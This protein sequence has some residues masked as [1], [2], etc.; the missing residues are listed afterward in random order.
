[1]THQDGSAH[2]YDVPDDDEPTVA[3]FRPRK[4]QSWMR[5]VSKAQ[6]PMK[7]GKYRVAL[8]AGG[9]RDVANQMREKLAKCR[10]YIK[11]HWE[12]DKEHSWNGEAH[13]DVD[14]AIFLKDFASHSQQ[15][16]F[17]LEMRDKGLRWIRTQRKMAAFTGALGQQGIRT[18]DAHGKRLEPL[19]TSV[20]FWG[21]D[22]LPKPKEKFP[23]PPKFALDKPA[24][25]DAAS[26]LGYRVAP[27]AVVDPTKLDLVNPLP[28]VNFV[29]QQAISPV[30]LPAPRKK[31][32]SPQLAVLASLLHQMCADEEVQVLCSPKELTFTAA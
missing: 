6:I 10:V 5:N 7:N 25:E 9:P 4:L 27:L 15:D 30:S 14:F 32:P 12:S 18:V 16:K 3:E 29:V 20:M 31:M 11:Y 21:E 23:E 8:L 2:S 13:S 17:V 24:I 26:K 1:M 28:T 22:L 19:N